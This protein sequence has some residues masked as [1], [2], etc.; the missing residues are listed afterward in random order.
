MLTYVAYV[1]LSIPHQIAKYQFSNAPS[2]PTNFE[3]VGHF[4]QVVWKGTTAVGCSAVTCPTMVGISYNNATI[5]VC[6]YDPPGELSGLR[7]D[8][9]CWLWMHG[10]AW[11]W[12]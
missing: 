6:S 2:S 7:L 4:T 10:V 3:S 12:A 8:P 9:L 5:V 11:C 1:H